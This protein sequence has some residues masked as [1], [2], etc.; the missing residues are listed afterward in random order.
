MRHVQHLTPCF[1]LR[2]AYRRGRGVN[3]TPNAIIPFAAVSTWGGKPAAVAVR[4]RGAV[5]AK[6]RPGCPL[7]AVECSGATW[8]RFPS[9]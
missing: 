2:T 4:A 8:R 6:L 3:G 7:H 5:G 1:A 9:T